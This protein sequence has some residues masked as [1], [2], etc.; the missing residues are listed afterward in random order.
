MTAQDLNQVTISGHIHSQ[1]QL[2]EYNDGDSAYTFTLT[3]TT[4]HHE[5]GHWELQL[6]SVSIW[7]PASH[8]F[9]EHFAVGQRV[10]ITGRLDCVCHE[11][12]T[13]YQPVV[14]IIAER[15]ITLHPSPQDN[16]SDQPQLALDR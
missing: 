8:A 2:H 4:D 9:I 5:S 14:S 16:G 13:G 15:I 6:Y 7:Q 11:T 10:A 12:L 3:H 1:P